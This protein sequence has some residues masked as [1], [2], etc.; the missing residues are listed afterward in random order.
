MSSDSCQKNPLYAPGKEGI[1]PGFSPGQFDGLVFEYRESVPCHEHCYCCMDTMCGEHHA[2]DYP[3]GYVA[4]A[5]SD[6]SEWEV[7]LCPDCYA[8][9]LQAGHLSSQV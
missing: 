9:L 4:T 6:L 5:R 8:W 7:W 2:D 3:D 1:G